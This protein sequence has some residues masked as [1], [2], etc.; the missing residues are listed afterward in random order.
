MIKGIRILTI[1]LFASLISSC[2]T[3]R[4]QVALRK[5]LECKTIKT[6]YDYG[7]N[8]P[9]QAINS[10]N[11]KYA[12]YAYHAAWNS[13]HN[14]NASKNITIKDKH[15]ANLNYVLAENKNYPVPDDFGRSEQMPIQQIL[16]STAVKLSYFELNKLPD[17]AGIINEP[18]NIIISPSQENIPYPIKTGKNHSDDYILLKRQ[19]VTDITLNESAGESSVS[20][21]DSGMSQPGKLPFHKSEAFV[22]MMAVLAGLIPLATIK[23]TPKLA[24]DISFW[25]AM[26]PWKT[27]IMFAAAQIALGTAG[28]MLGVKLADNGVHFSALSWDLS[29]GSFLFSSLLYPAKN[30][31][32]NL[33]KHTYLRQKA[34]DLALA[35][36]GFML[37]VNTGND[38][39]TR[40]SF[41]KMVNF[42]GYERQTVNITDNQNPVPT[43]LLYHQ[44]DKQL[45]DKQTVVPKKERSNADNIILT[46]LAVLATLVLGF[47]VAAAACSLSCNG[48]GGLAALTGIGGGALVLVLAIWAIKSIWHPKQRNRIRN[49]RSVQQEA[50]FKV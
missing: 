4:F 43:Q 1:L 42:N 28:F 39:G 17:P 3:D 37:M 23:S 14:G 44:S 35:I 33:F 46:T 45:Q 15:P 29:L 32:F 2:A 18:R 30:T 7:R 26:N 24:A 5:D 48:M 34:F 6:R 31:S 27:R 36:S 9:I 8:K 11:R 41:G 40:S 50:T 13:V 25:A 21:T 16:K 12:R 47:I 20:T 22:L 38:T 19:D 49:V 10:N